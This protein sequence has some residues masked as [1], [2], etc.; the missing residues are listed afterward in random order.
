MAVTANFISIAKTNA[1]LVGGD[2]L[3]APF[4]T[5]TANL[6]FAR[7]GNAATEPPSDADATLTALRGTAERWKESAA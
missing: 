1:K 4:K 3:D 5:I 6:T 2:V 7:Q